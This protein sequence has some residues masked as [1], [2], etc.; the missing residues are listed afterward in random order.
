MPLNSSCQDR[1]WD[2]G[3]E[4]KGVSARL[5]KE[6]GVCQTPGPSPMQLGHSIPQNHSHGRCVCWG[7]KGVLPFLR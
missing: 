3:G 4:V 1:P 5:H 7:W 2:E 6:G